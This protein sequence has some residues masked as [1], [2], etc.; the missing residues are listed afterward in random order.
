MASRETYIKQLRITNVQITLV[1]MT[2]VV[3]EQI[4]IV[5][6]EGDPYHVVQRKIGRVMELLDCSEEEAERLVLNKR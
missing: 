6:E 4:D 5:D 3:E 2:S 1:S